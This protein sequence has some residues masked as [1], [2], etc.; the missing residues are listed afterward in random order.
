[1]L[2]TSLFSPRMQQR[3]PSHCPSNHHHF[4]SPHFPSLPTPPQPCTAVKPSPGLGPMG[5]HVQLA[6]SSTCRRSP[7]DARSLLPTWFLLAD[8]RAAEKGSPNST[9]PAA[10][11]GHGFSPRSLIPALFPCWKYLCPAL[12][13]ALNALNPINNAGELMAGSL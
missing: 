11:S 3:S 1:M 8:G 13:R 7:G 5:T 9:L 10:P 12:T 4:W 2:S 6:A